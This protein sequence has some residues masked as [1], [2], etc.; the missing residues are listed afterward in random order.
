MRKKRRKSALIEEVRKLPLGHL[1]L[2]GKLRRFTRQ[3]KTIGSLLK[4]VEELDDVIPKDATVARSGLDLTLQDFYGVTHSDGTIDWDSFREGRS[5]DP[6][7]LSLYFHSPLLAELDVHTRRQALAALHFK[8]RAITELNAI[9]VKTIGDLVRRARLG[10]ESFCAARSETSRDVV[11]ALSTLAQN[12]QHGSVDWISFA[13]GRGFVIFPEEQKKRWAPSDFVANLPTLAEKAV[14]NRYGPRALV[15]LRKR[16]LASENSDSLQKVGAGFDRTRERI[17]VLEEQIINMFAGIFL[18]DEYEGCKFRLRPE[19]IE[20]LRSLEART[21]DFRASSFTFKEWEKLL[22]KLWR[23]H[24]CDV[25]PAE[26]LILELLNHPRL[27]NSRPL[28]RLIPSSKQ[29]FVQHCKIVNE[30][31]RLLTRHYPDGLTAESLRKT[32]QKKFKFPVINCVKLRSLAQSNPIL[33]FNGGRIR[34]RTS[35]LIHKADQAERLLRQAGKPRLLRD[36]AR[37]I[38]GPEACM[39]LHATRCL[40]QTMSY[41]RRLAAIGVSGFWALTEWDFVDARS[42]PKI[43]ADLLRH[44]KKPLHQK[45]LFALISSRRPVKEKS[46][47]RMLD[48]DARF[49]NVGPCT[50]K[51]RG[52]VHAQPGVPPQE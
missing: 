35:Y 31:E 52:Q 22:K 28:L 15:I 8:H 1:Q 11:R 14:E 38:L 37:E 12:V 29:G 34:A 17:R 3:F 42:V 16:L 47:G 44:S 19:F 4:A 49:Q 50:W 51:L 2:S 24:P 20:P 23:M 41:D 36:L 27:A 43:A 40:S 46:I 39:D 21:R 45:E 26:R 33:E 30:V 6:N 48:A 32:L 10:I 5:F 18:A 13:K 7:S 25:A 9:G